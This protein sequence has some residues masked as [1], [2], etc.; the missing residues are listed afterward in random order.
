M[1]SA[2][3]SRTAFSRPEARL[4]L[5]LFVAWPAEDRTGRAL[6][7]AL[8]HAL[9]ALVG[10]VAGGRLV[11]VLIDAAA[12][13]PARAVHGL[14]ADAARQLE[15]VHD[16]EASLAIDPR[17]IAASSLTDYRA[18]GINRVSLR[19]GSLDETA[20]A[21]LATAAG[22]FPRCALDLTFGR[23]RQS[24]AG[25]RAELDRAV[26]LGACHI[27]LEEHSVAAEG[28]SSDRAA[29]FYHLAIDRLGAAGLPPYEIAHFAR[30]G[31]EARQL[32]HGAIGGDYLGIGPGAVGRV[33]IGGV[34]HALA[35]VEPATAWLRAVETGAETLRQ[36][37]RADE[38]RTE[39]LLS[40]LRL[41]AGIGRIW[42]EPVAGPLEAALD[43]GRLEPLIADGFV[44][45][46]RQG[47]RLTERGW[48]FCDG[49]LARLLH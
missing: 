32:L 46:D 18:A 38:R 45:L 33:T 42:F 48:P 13:P 5:A 28:V 21:A 19:A 27:S 9:P 47:L 16:L 26:Q 39:L 4:A 36:E 8:D 14:L 37:L 31:H 17:A 11:S 35:Q 40:G 29:A 15:V 25:W 30:P 20:Q 12:P 41:R 2:A 49:V 10:G 43:A 34:C 24:L 6:R 22:L 44:E 7:L 23:P 1:P 3:C